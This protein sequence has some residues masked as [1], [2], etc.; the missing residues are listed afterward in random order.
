MYKTIYT[1]FKDEAINYEPFQQAVMS[2]TNKE[3]AIK[4]LQEMIEEVKDWWKRL[5]KFD[6]MVIDDSVPYYFDIYE[7]FNKPC[8]H[9][10]LSIMENTLKESVKTLW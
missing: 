9:T 5:G 2:F 1:L 6:E 7:S 10:T 3:D 4:H 8:N